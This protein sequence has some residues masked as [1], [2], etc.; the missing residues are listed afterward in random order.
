ME[1]NVSIKIT[2]G[3]YPQITKNSRKYAAVRFEPLSKEEINMIQSKS[4]SLSKSSSAN[5]S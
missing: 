3:K 5:T 2:C 1:I 4:S